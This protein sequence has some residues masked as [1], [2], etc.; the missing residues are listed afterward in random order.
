MALVQHRL[1]IR[2]TP[3]ATLEGV[4][5]YTCISQ[6]LSVP[7][8]DRTLDVCSTGGSEWVDIVLRRF[9]HNHVKYHARSRLV[10]GTLSYSYRM[11]S[12]VIN[13]AQ[14][15]RQHCTLQAFEQFV[16]LHIV[17]SDLNDPI[18]HSDECQ[19]GSFSSEATICTMWYCMMH[20]PDDKYP[21]RPG[22]EPS[23]WVSSHKRAK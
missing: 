21:T 8:G 18:C 15:H 20:S 11:N 14:Y 3:F 9:L 22:F 1:H 10:F 6:K 2:P 4:A 5:S 17:A 19:I 23:T 12:K 16:V 13:I 7:S